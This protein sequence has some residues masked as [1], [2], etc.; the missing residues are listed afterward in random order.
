M[1]KLFKN[2]LKNSH[3][4]NWKAIQASIV[5]W[6]R[7]E[8]AL[9]NL[10]NLIIPLLY[11]LLT[12]SMH[13]LYLAV[14]FLS[15]PAL[16]RG[17][18][19]G[20]SD[21]PRLRLPSKENMWSRHQRLFEENIRKKNQKMMVCVFWKWGFRSCLQTRKILAPHASVTRNGSL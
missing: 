14:S 11:L 9:M 8:E 20:L 12:Y 6:K 3:E 17:H 21:G 4:R 7:I 10:S 5:K 19:K 13:A 1:R 15:R 18:E 16:R 2:L